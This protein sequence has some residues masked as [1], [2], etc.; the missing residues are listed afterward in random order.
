MM[1]INKST[2][3]IEHGVKPTF[4]NGCQEIE[5]N[6]TT[7][8]ELTIR[9]TNRK[10]SPKPS[11]SESESKVKP[12]ASGYDATGDLDIQ[13]TESLEDGLELEK[14]CDDWFSKTPNTL[15][16]LTGGTLPVMT[17]AKTD[18]THLWGG[19]RMEIGL[20]E[21]PLQICE[22]GVKSLPDCVPPSFEDQVSF[23]PV[24]WDC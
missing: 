4:F 12:T 14:C 11:Q 21:A 2:P 19:D 22:G 20:Q 5:V 17:S 6:V 13:N 9:S 10:P 8:G 16:K 1:H 3:T 18:V 7:G 24:Y 15:A 23:D